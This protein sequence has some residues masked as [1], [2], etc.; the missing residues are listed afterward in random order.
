MGKGPA[1]R[2]RVQLADGRATTVHVATYPLITTRLRFARL[3]PEAPLEAWCAREGIS[4]AVSGG[5]ATKPGYE[6]LGE[7]W[8]DGSARSHVPF[9]EPWHERRGALAALDGDGVTI[10]W[11]DRLPARPDGGLLQAGPLL[12]RD[13]RSAIAGVEDPEGF[14][15]TAE[16]F[17]EDITADREP[18]LAVA[19]NRSVLL[20][21]AADGRS[22]EDAGLTLWE[23]ADLLVDLGAE[24]ALNLDGGS[25]A[26]IVAGGERV[27][28]PRD[29][30]GEDMPESSPTV[31]ALVFEG[32]LS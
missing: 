9:A 7:L 13:G 2:R 30:E 24:R 18:R 26:A 8:V 10:D 14:S 4:E 22:P 16:E 12:V 29:D 1:T 17:D 31:S 19:I 5:F 32:A 6:P 27:N 3:E 23:F 21:V 15:S 25:A 28:T 11:R 20:A